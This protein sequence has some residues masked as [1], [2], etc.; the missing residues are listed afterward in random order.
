MAL[1]VVDEGEYFWDL[2]PTPL[3]GSGS[4]EDAGSVELRLGPPASD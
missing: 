1:T 4:K 3:A 2:C